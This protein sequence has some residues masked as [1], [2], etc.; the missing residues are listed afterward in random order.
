MEVLIR[1]RR[2]YYNQSNT[3]TLEFRLIMPKNPPGH[4]NEHHWQLK[5]GGQRWVKV[6]VNW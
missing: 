3:K 4:W 2:L 6:E 5:R 1:N